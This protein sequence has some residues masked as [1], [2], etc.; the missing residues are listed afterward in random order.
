MGV[1]G[2]RP[3]AGRKKGSLGK[4]TIQQRGTLEEIARTY[5]QDALDVLVQ[6]ARESQ[7]DAARVSAAN[8]LLD[9]GYGKP[10]QHT[11]LTGKDGGDIKVKLTNRQ[12]AQKLAFILARGRSGS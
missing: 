1:G 2:K 11:E 10:S 6:V 7:S 3:G 12:R 8:A 4:A 9:R 5:T